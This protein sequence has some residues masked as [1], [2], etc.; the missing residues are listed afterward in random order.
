MRIAGAHHG[1][2]IFENLNVP[3]IFHSGQFLKLFDPGVDDRFYLVHRHGCESEIMARRKANHA[4]DARLGLGN[5]Q[6]LVV[7]V[8]SSVS[9]LSFQSRKIIVEDER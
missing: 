3:D 1:P 2:A 6:T 7:D 8:E 4:A 9:R 5:Q